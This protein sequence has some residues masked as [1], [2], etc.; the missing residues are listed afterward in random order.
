MKNKKWKIYLV[1][2]IVL[3]I[4]ISLIIKGRQNKS[5]NE[6]VREISP[7]YGSIQTFISTTGTV[8]PQN[9]LEIK[10]P[11]SGR[12]EEILVKEG[13]IVTVGQILAW[14]SSTER[15]ALLDTAHSPH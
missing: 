12:I 10:P 14:M 8:Q 6:L 11:I 5:S 7:V 3:V 13:Q 2:L 4:S 15:A 9:R 1:L